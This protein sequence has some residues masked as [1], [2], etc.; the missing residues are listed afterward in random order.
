V[1]IAALTSGRH[2]LMNKDPELANQWSRIA[3]CA[4]PLSYDRTAVIRYGG[5]MERSLP[6][7]AFH[8]T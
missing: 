8:F 4:R 5:A 3:R 1:T 7:R 2:Q 6:S